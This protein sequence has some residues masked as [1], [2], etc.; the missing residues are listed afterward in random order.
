MDSGDN[1]KL[2]YTI[3]FGND[4]RLFSIEPVKGDLRIARL[5]NV[6]DLDKIY[7]LVLS[8]TDQGKPRL[9][10]FQNLKIIIQLNDNANMLE[11][12]SGFENDKNLLKKD[13]YYLNYTMFSGRQRVLLALLFILILL[14]LLIVV[15]VLLVVC[16]NHYKEFNGD[17][18]LRNFQKMDCHIEVN[19]GNSYAEFSNSFNEG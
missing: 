6:E 10:S 15:L 14:V 1:A 13:E 16:C 19:Q 7:F 9:S 17:N 12:N 18:F 2:T 5:L 8:A 11:N 3:A 4:E